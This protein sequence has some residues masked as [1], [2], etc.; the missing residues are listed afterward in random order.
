MNQLLKRDAMSRR[1]FLE[2]GSAALGVH[3][4]SS[5]ERMMA[6]DARPPN[7]L[8]IITDQESQVFEEQVPRALL[9]LPNRTSLERQGIRLT[10][11]FVVAPQCSA[12]RS[13]LMTGLYPHQTGVVTN[14]DKGSLGRRLSPT[15]PT[16]GKAFQDHGYTTAYL[17]KWHLTN[18]LGGGISPAHDSKALIP[19]GFEHYHFLSDARTPPGQLSNAAANWIRQ[20]P[21]SPWLLIVSFPFLPHDINRVAKVMP[22]IKIRP[23]MTLPPN[24][25]DDLHHKPRP[26]E[27]YMQHDDGEVALRWGHEDWLRYRSYYLDLIE[28]IDRSLGIILEALRRRSDADDTIVVYTSDHGDMGGAHQMP[29]KGPFMYDEL[30]RVPLVIS[31]PRR[32]R[33]PVVSDSMVSNIDLVPT[34]AGLAGIEWPRPLPGRD[35]SMLFDYP[36]EGVRATVFAEYYGKQ[37]WVNPIRT[38]R[39][40]DWKY[41][42]YVAPGREIIAEMY[43]LKRDPGELHNIVKH[44][45]YQN[46]QQSLATNL[47]EWRRNTNDPML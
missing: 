45:G 17:G 4:L 1:G 18:G 22:T 10:H 7:V 19:F 42:L 36:K 25:K 16:L 35:F 40:G 28:R 24:F 8:V 21:P 23:G 41:N 29:F 31:Y 15:I 44:S 11:A 20:A 39:T 5:R 37:H 34:L 27:E 13:T 26:Q 2:A 3:F 43:D 47:L 46:A 38:I 12:S 9:R 32:F 33:K 14:V 30:L 6:N